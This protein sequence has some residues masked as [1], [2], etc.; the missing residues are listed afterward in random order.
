MLTVVV[1]F[2]GLCGFKLVPLYMDNFTLNSTLKN[3]DVPRGQVNDMTSTEILDAMSKAFA[4]IG[5]RL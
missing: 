5:E 2:F 3:L 4:V 1:A